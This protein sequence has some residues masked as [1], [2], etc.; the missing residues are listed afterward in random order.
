[1]TQNNIEVDR[2][3]HQ[4]ENLAHIKIPELPTPNKQN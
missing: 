4:E 2:C 3:G 1:M